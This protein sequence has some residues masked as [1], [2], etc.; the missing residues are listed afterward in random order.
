MPDSTQSPSGA[1]R[2]RPGLA[3]EYGVSSKEEGM[4]EWS[5]V[6]RRMEK[7]RN[8][9]VA[10]TRPDGRPHSMPVWGV[11]V[12]GSLYFGTGPET[13]KARNLSENPSMVIHP[14]SGDEVAILE[15]VAEVAKDPELLS[16]IDDA[17]EAKY[18]MRAVSMMQGSVWYTLRPQRAFAWTE[19]EFPTN[20]T[21]WI[22]G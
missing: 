4:L 22:W 13:C 12:D 9:W 11:W 3:Q 20:A 7:S 6:S 5:W 2:D 1:R 18:G 21:R 19:K 17:Y 14:E 8:Y 10:T 16:R 15:G